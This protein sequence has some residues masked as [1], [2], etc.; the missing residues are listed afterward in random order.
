M[1]KL[2][3]LPQAFHGD[4][5]VQDSSALVKP[6]TIAQEAGTAFNEWI[7]LRGTASVVLGT[8]VRFD[9]NFTTTRSTTNDVGLH[10]VAGTAHTASTYGWFQ[11][12]GINYNA[13]VTQAVA[14]DAGLYLHDAAGMVDDADAAGELIEGAFSM[15]AS[16]GSAVTVMLAYPKT[17]NA[18]QD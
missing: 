9:E 12:R 18:A 13:Q 3:G 1:A 6:G 10:A 15:A 4:T 7:Y 17:Y 16:S 11:I 14:A 5:T 2:A 8:W